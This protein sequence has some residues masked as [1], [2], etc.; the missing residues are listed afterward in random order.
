[1]PAK[2]GR[3]KLPGN[4]TAYHSIEIAV[5]KPGLLQPGQARAPIPANTGSTGSVPGWQKGKASNKAKGVRTPPEVLLAEKYDPK[6]IDLTERL[7]SDGEWIMIVGLMKD[8]KIHSSGAG[9]TNAKDMEDLALKAKALAMA[10]H[11]TAA[12]EDLNAELDAEEKLAA[13]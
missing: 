8:G 12:W 2:E 1:M 7:K 9:G 4:D 10:A 3:T 6:P 11:R 5:S 13:T